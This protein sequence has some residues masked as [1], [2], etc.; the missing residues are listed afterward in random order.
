MSLALPGRFGLPLYIFSLSAPG[1]NERYFLSYFKE[2]P[3]S[4]IVLLEDIHSAGIR[5]EKATS[6][7]ISKSRS[8]RVPS[9]GVDA[10]SNDS[11][12]DAAGKVGV[13]L[14]ALLN[15]IDGS[16]QVKVVF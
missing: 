2:L 3:T 6:K 10:D 7:R 1:L 9:R 11:D 5:R 16:E 14:F 12:S 15:A 13:T 8:M 4:C